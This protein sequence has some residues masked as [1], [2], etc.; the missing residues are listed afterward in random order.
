MGDAM[1]AL[2]KLCSAFA[3]PSLAFLGH[4]YVVVFPLLLPAVGRLGGQIDIVMFYNV[5]IRIIH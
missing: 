1:H 4:V 3:I 2:L 5:A